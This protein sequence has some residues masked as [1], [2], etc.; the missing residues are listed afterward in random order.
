MSWTAG[1]HLV[2]RRLQSLRPPFAQS[3]SMSR[4]I[5]HSRGSLRP[6]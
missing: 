2:Q 4:A 3:T 1:G 5:S 6:R